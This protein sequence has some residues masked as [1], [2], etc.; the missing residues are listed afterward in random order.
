V[1]TVDW[2]RIP[3]PP[4]YKPQDAQAAVES[5]ARAVS[6]GQAARAVAD[7]R[8]AVSNDHGGLLYPA[9]VPAT[10]VFL[11]VI[12]ERPGSPRQE[13]LNALSDWWGCFA[14]EPGF[15]SYHDLMTGPVDVVAAIMGHVRD[16]ADLLRGVAVDPSGGGGH[17][18]GVKWLLVALE[19]SWVADDV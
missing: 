3:G 14:P 13:A 5:L 18:P 8:Y 11:E 9:A 17:R 7:L 19:K 4:C 16:A 2:A 10:R 15:E 6:T 1:E 12:R